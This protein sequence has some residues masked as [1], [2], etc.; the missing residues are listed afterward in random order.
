MRIVYMLPLI[1]AWAAAPVAA[2]AYVESG[3]AA[4]ETADPKARHS[5]AQIAAFFNAFY[6]GKYDQALSH[7]SK[8]EVPDT[9]EARA[10]KTA[11]RAGA[12]LGLKRTDEARRL[13]D[14]AD[15]LWPAQPFVSGMQLEAAIITDHM[16]IARAALDRMIARYPDAV[17]ELDYNLLRWLILEDFRNRSTGGDDRLVAL[18]RLGYGGTEQGEYITSKAVEILLGRGDV[19]G[20]AELVPHVDDPRVVEDMLI[21]KR[22]SALWP[23]LEQHSG[24]RLEKIRAS[25]AGSAERAY[26][27]NPLSSEKLQN[28]AI[29]L[30]HAG[31]HSE[32]IALRSKV[33]AT[34]E[35]MASADEETGWVVNEIALAMHE[36][37]RTE[38]ADQLFAL[39]NDAPMPN[40]RGGWRVSMIINRLELL[41]SDGKFDKALPL[42]ERTERSA[43]EGG[44]PYARQLV[45]RLKYCTLSGLGRK[46]ETDKLL[47]EMV[48][49]A[50]DAWH[51]TVDGLLCAG[52]VDK[53]EQVALEALKAKDEDFEAQFVRTLQL[54]PLTS[55]DPSIWQGRWTALRQRPALAREFE[56][57]G[58]D[59]PDAFVPPVPAKSRA[60]AGN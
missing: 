9:K 35:L 34:R 32:V 16:D 30:R 37:G 28:L 5:D 55:D 6:D 54:K 4:A 59:M 33:P 48:A 18:A 51:A 2:S 8:L 22:Y 56:R 46:A 52:E 1:A 40:G 44:S 43:V 20:A 31:R 45:R 42:L 15:K 29:A 58:R 23:K 3:Q 49:H 57:L 21:Q 53:A 7:A 41:V 50:K 19:V 10:L 60:S 24:A 11:L 13:F 12:L 17:R 25:S 39:L 47:P 14:E 26:A 27:E 38:E 36:T